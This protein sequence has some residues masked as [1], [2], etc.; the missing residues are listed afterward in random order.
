MSRNVLVAGV[1]LLVFLIVAGAVYLQILNSAS[2]SDTVWAVSR[3]VAAGDQLTGDVVRQTHI[4]AS[5]DTWDFYS[6]D[7]LAAHARAS[8]D[9]AAGTI[10]FKKDVQTQDMA[11]VTLSLRTPP[12]LTHGMTIDVYAY[13]ASGTQTVGRHL[14]VNQYQGGTASVW[15]PAADEPEWITLQANNVALYAAVSNGVGVPQTRGQGVQEALATLG[16]GSTV[17][18]PVTTAPTPFPTAVPTKK[19]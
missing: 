5:G 4:P 11:L 10:V 7:L 12:P 3:A 2:R 9:M 1:G 19:P 13:S 15:V 16:G 18:G 8:H 14:A 6:G 17:G